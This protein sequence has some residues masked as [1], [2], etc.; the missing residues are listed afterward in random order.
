MI[1][2]RALVNS[3]LGI[4]AMCVSAYAAADS[5]S[6]APQ[7]YLLLTFNVVDGQPDPSRVFDLVRNGVIVA[8]GVT[9][10]QGR[11]Y[12]SAHVPGQ[13]EDWLIRFKVPH[14]VAAIDQNTIGALDNEY[15][16]HIDADGRH[17]GSLFYTPTR[18]TDLPTALGYECATHPAKACSTQHFL[19]METYG[20]Q[21]VIGGAHYWIL[22][23]GKVIDSGR[24]GA[25]GMIYVRDPR[26]QSNR[27]LRLDLAFCS[28]AGFAIEQDAEGTM[29]AQRIEHAQYPAELQSKMSTAC[30]RDALAD[31]AMQGANY[32][33]GRPFVHVGQVDASI[34]VALV[35]APASKLVSR[36]RKLDPGA[37]E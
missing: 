29:N 3:I 5:G 4:V 19:W 36:L 18:V 37:S 6:Q 30:R 7:R 11:V 14:Y 25:E 13:A 33:Q 10:A 31:Y 20:Y 27:P 15:L 17:T 22:E 24:S 1:K 26:T 16:V 21:R 32:L 2:K 9:D 35:D 28:G 34:P 12:T 23:D 8:N